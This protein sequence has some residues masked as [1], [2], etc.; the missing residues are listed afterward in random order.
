MRTQCWLITL[1]MHTGTYKWHRCAI[2]Q[3]H[4]LFL[5]LFKSH[6]SS[7]RNRNK[8]NTFCMTQKC[9][10]YKKENIRK[11]HELNVRG[12]YVELWTL[13]HKTYRACHQL[14]FWALHVQSQE[15]HFRMKMSWTIAQTLA[16]EYS[17]AWEKFSFSVFPESFRNQT[18]FI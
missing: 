13:L 17:T 12:H 6:S 16:F 14:H 8:I 3:K 10:S 7:L 18:D 9:L 5:G 11:C 1:L 4:K 15:V 2:S